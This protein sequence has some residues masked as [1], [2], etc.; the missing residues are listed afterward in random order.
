M[1]ASPKNMK[2]K[3]M[4]IFLSASIPDP[5]RDSIYWDTADLTAIR[6]AVRAL[7]TVVLPRSKLIWG[8]HP[9]ITPLIRVV[10]ESMDIKIKEH[11]F[12]YQSE[13]F[14]SQFPSDNEFFENVIY[15]RAGIDQLSSLK[16]MR[17]LMIGHNAFDAG[18]F[19]GGM[20]GV[21]EE[22]EFFRRFHPNK[23]VFPIASTGAAARIIFE[24]CCLNMPE[25]AD[26]FTYNSLFR[27]LLKQIESQSDKER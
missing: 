20:E 26:D 4:I 25:L 12:L 19:I 18:I 7:A 23:P 10:A 21:V 15:S 2:D 11:V 16:I 27:R 9:A 3:L 6:D 24:K 13:F 17:N 5:K 14:R 1:V 22:F 8:G